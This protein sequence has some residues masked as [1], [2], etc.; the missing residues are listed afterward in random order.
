MTAGPFI[1]GSPMYRAR[2]S[3]QAAREASNAMTN[4][5]MSENSLRAHYC[6]NSM[7]PHSVYRKILAIQNPPTTH[8]RAEDLIVFVDEAAEAAL[9]AEY[10]PRR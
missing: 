4:N 5:A 7:Q 10:G 3:T 2:V 6:A 9:I 1:Y 8:R